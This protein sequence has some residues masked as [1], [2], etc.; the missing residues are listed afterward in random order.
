MRVDRCLSLNFL[1]S[2]ILSSQGSKSQD[3]GPYFTGFHQQRTLPSV[4]NWWAAIQ[5]LIFARW[6]GIHSQPEP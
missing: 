3:N 2:L 4:L 1:F 5:C 6:G